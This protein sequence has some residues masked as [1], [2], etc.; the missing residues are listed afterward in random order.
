ML[1]I[2]GLFKN[3][4]EKEFDL[5][6]DLSKS[7][8]T[9]EKAHISGILKN[10]AGVVSINAHI[11]GSYKGICDR[12]GDGFVLELSADVNTILSMD[13]S[14]DDSVTV[15]DGSIDLEKT[16]YDTLVIEMPILLLCSENCL[17]LCQKCGINLNREKCE[18]VSDL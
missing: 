2:I 5:D 4:G 16:V 3:N 13:G 18:H 15:L 11:S 9:F 7:D 12:C 14:D 17:G 1:N 8:P 6:I 10:I